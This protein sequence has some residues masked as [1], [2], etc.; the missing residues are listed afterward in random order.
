MHV[1]QMYGPKNKWNW[2]LEIPYAHNDIGE[3]IQERCQLIQ[4]S[5]RGEDSAKEAK[6]RTMKA[7]IWYFVMRLARGSNDPSKVL[8]GFEDE[9]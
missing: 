9:L 2:F 3:L 7:F 5:Y 6:D 8:K 1:W 4:S